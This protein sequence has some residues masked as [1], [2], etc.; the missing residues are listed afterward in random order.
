MK[1]TA[2]RGVI[3]IILECNKACVPR[4]GLWSWSRNKSWARGAV[5]FILANISWPCDSNKRV[6][7]TRK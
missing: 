7:A 2:Q 4:I 6:R 5:N 1:R 3:E